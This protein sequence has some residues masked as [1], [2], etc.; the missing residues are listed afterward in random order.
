[1]SWEN[2]W[3]IWNELTAR[4]REALRRTA[5]VLRAFPE[6]L[7]S[8]DWRPFWTTEQTGVFASAFPGS[9]RTLWTLINR[10]E[11]DVAGPQ[12]RVP[13]TEGARYF[14]FWSGVEL[15]PELH[16]SEAVLEFRVEAGGFGAVLKTSEPLDEPEAKLLDRARD[17]SQSPLRAAS[18]A[19]TPERQML[20][21]I[22]ATARAPEAPPGMVRIEGGPYLF[23][24]S[25]VEIE[26][27]DLAGV[28]VQ[29]PWEDAP[30]RHHR[31]KI[32]VAPF[33]ID[34]HPVTNKEFQIFVES[35]G[36]RPED[37]HNFL[38][39]WR[40]GTYAEGWADKPVTW[41]SIEDARAYARW[42]GKR[43]PR[44]W[45]WQYA[46]QGPDRRRYPWGNEWNPSAVPPPETAR[47][48]GPPPDVGAFPG[49]A[50]PFGVEDLVGTVWQWT[51]EYVDSHTRAAILRGGSFYRPQGSRWYFPQAYE[52]D[53]HG[54][55]LL[56]A[57]SLDRSGAIGFRLV[58][59]AQP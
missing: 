36:Y 23:A 34:R 16:E 6:L 28:D 53:E 27:G 19:W 7:T 26:G 31:H 47:S 14:D 33:F 42:A 18:T 44:E 29:L 5:A 52:L 30:R 45:E 48:M 56:M 59:D 15:S 1:V 17:W 10:N 50:S 43:L 25:G 8:R 51:D 39:H 46:A 49:G 35:A 21:D 54:K 57:P 24:V 37:D 2:I 11:H 22:P 41:V 32:H 4:D 9:S 40:G 20:L 12:L 3:G 55:Y 13:H 58:V 38:K